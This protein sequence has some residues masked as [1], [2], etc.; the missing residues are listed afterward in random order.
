MSLLEVR[1]LT[2]RYGRRTA[3]EDLSFA[4][5]AG[6]IL[7]LLGPSGSGKTTTL[8]LIAGFERPDDGWLRLSGRLLGSPERSL[9]PERR[10]IGYVFQEYVLFPHL[11]V[12]ENVAFGL[13][14]MAARERRERT[15]R[16]LEQVGLTAFARRYPHELSGGQQ[17]RVAL[18]R[19]LAPEPPLVLLDEPFS[20]L[21]AA[22]REGTRREVLGLLRRRGVGT[23]LVTHDQEE[24]L[25]AADRIAVLRE[26]RIEQIG[27]PEEVYHRP[28]TAFV[29]HFLGSTNLLSGTARG[30]VAD[31][32][33]GPV[34]LDRAAEGRVLLSL[35]P[36]HLELGAEGAPVVVEAR[37]F[38][39]HD[40][41]LQVRG[42][43][44]SFRVQADY[45]LPFR[46]GDTARLRA[47]ERAVV[48]ASPAERR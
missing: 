9:P 36:E 25:A 8:R 1:E 24:A 10:G 7:A 15:R 5:D 13:R 23:L 41:T 44:G 32:P 37:S 22:L 4:L 14:R 11:N 27:S 18:A 34:E 19:A 21:D 39:G 31:T 47:R 40:V 45:R 3:V 12:Y 16:V 26:G 6:E 20:S 48:L 28:R 29:A 33:L 30:R 43:A 42:P 35:R 38:K 46:P 17:Q 2:K